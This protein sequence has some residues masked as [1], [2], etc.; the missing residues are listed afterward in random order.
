MPITN[1]RLANSRHDSIRSER[2]RSVWRIPSARRPAS[3]TFFVIDSLSRFGV[4]YGRIGRDARGLTATEERRQPDHGGATNFG[5]GGHQH[6]GDQDEQ[7]RAAEIRSLTGQH[8]AQA[9]AEQPEHAG[10]RDRQTEEQSRSEAAQN[11]D[12]DRGRDGRQRDRD[13]CPEAAGGRG[14]GVEHTGQPRGARRGT[15]DRALDGAGAVIGGQQP[16]RGEP[17]PQRR[18]R[19]PPTARA[20]QAQA[21]A[22]RP[23]HQARQ[24][25]QQRCT[26][27]PGQRVRGAGEEP[28]EP[29][30]GEPDAQPPDERHHQ[31]WLDAAPGEHAQAD[32]NLNRRG[33]PVEQGDM[34]KDRL[35]DPGDRTPDHPGLPCRVGSQH[36]GHERP[37]EHER[38]QLQQA[39]DQ[40]DQAEH[41]L[42]PVR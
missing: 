37:T 1:G 26:G 27:R 25:V 42:R 3:S 19:D 22:R 13:R 31:R 28:A 39:I 21:T 5:I 20:D 38:L 6:A 11:A 30:S 9:L 32:Q 23:T 17:Q 35:S 36:V 7:R 4:T 29:L 12:P 10:Q 14:G 41:D 40:P 2:T 33:E 24:H 18:P 34:G 8:S 16:Q 15:G